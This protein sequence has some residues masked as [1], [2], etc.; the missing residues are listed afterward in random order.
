MAH[1]NPTEFTYAFEGGLPFR[2]SGHPK[3]E[4]NRM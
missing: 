3:K 2:S 1:V 4:V